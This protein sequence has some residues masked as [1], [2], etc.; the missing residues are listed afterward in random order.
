MVNIFVEKP[1]IDEELN[2]QNVYDEREKFVAKLRIKCTNP[3]TGHRLH[4]NKVDA[5]PGPTNFTNITVVIKDLFY[6]ISVQMKKIKE[7]LLNGTSS[8]RIGKREADDCG[9][10]KSIWRPFFV[11]DTIPSFRN[12]SGNYKCFVLLQNIRNYFNCRSMPQLMNNR[13]TGDI[14]YSDVLQ[15]LYPSNL[16]PPDV[17]GLYSKWSVPDNLPVF[18]PLFLLQWDCRFNLLFDHRSTGI[19]FTYPITSGAWSLF[20]LSFFLISFF[21][22]FL[23]L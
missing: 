7:I 8:I 9:Q 5:K 21:S 10:Y 12:K 23:C 18:G 11:V 20:R 16:L 22:W 6:L 13:Y 1:V 4:N 2:T 14:I 17:F 19:F 15:P 3:S